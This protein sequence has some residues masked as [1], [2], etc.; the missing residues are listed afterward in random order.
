MAG[1]QEGDRVAYGT[2]RGVVVPWPSGCGVLGG[3]LIRIT[4]PR[5]REGEL[6]AAP[7]W[8]AFLRPLGVKRLRSRHWCRVDTLAVLG[9]ALALFAVVSAVMAL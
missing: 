1:Y 9:I 5:H 8:S 7:E 6:L 2:V 3:V 4:E